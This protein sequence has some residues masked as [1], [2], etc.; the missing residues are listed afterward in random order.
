MGRNVVG[1]KLMANT[2]QFNRGI[3]SA[4]RN[5]TSLDYM[6]AR[7]G[8]AA[9]RALKAGGFD[10]DTQEKWRGRF[11]ALGLASGAALTAG[12][13]M[14]M[15]GAILWQKVFSPALE[16]AASFQK[17]MARMT[18]LAG[19]MGANE[20][21]QFRD[22]ALRIGLRTQFSGTE[23][24]KSMSNLMT[25]GLTKGQAMKTVEPMIEAIEA[26]FGEIAPE[27]AAKIFAIAMNKFNLPENLKD[28]GD[29]AKY[30]SDMLFTLKKSSR[31]EFTE[32]LSFLDS[33]QAGP[34]ILNMSMKET[35]ALGTALMR[36]GTSGRRSG[37]QISSLAGTIAKIH[38]VFE[39]DIGTNRFGA[40][41][42]KANEFYDKEGIAGFSERDFKTRNNQVK[43]GFE[44]LMTI[45]KRTNQLAEKT[46]DPAKARAALHALLSEKTGLTVVSAIRDMKFELEGVNGEAGKTLT[47]LDAMMA[48][49]QS[50][51][52]D[53]IRGT[54][55]KG[56]EAYR[57]TWEGT[58]K[59]IEGVVDTIYTLFGEELLKELNPILQSVKGFL[60]TISELTLKSNF[61]RRSILGSVGALTLFLLV[62]G[63]ALLMMGALGLIFA[64]AA[65]G[66]MIFAEAM[67]V[68]MGGLLG[69][70]ALVTF[71]VGMISAQLFGGIMMLIRGLA[72]SK[73]IKSFIDNIGEMKKAWSALMGFWEGN[74]IPKSQWDD[75]DSGFQKLIISILLVRDGLSALWESFNKELRWDWIGTAFDHLVG[76]MDVLGNSLGITNDFGQTGIST[77]EKLG[78][79]MSW[80]LN[81]AIIAIAAGIYLM[82]AM[83]NL[84]NEL[85]IEMKRF[86]ANK[87]LVVGVKIALG[88]IL[89][90]LG[91]IVISMGLLMLM[92]SAFGMGIGMAV[93]LIVSIMAAIWKFVGTIGNLVGYVVGIFIFIVGQAFNVLWSFV[94]ALI[95]QAY[96]KGKSFADS[97]ADGFRNREAMLNKLIGGVIRTTALGTESD[98][99]PEWE[100]FGTRFTSP[101]TMSP[102]PSAARGIQAMQPG[103]STGAAGGSTTNRTTSSNV[104]VGNIIVKS[105]LEDP[106]A[107]KE[108]TSKILKALAG[109]LTEDRVGENNV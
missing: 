85:Y 87:Q 81:I 23:V 56:A 78:K 75:V 84:W 17:E 62:A 88:G 39:E 52:Q 22:K 91:G 51:D 3:N 45:A 28:T 47:G 40:I 35:F 69:V 93:A 27:Q 73:S 103:V 63:V 104:S 96:G 2:R 42:K 107:I 26:S 36:L 99:L 64:L 25:A 24:A 1:I 20:F 14:S 100:S 102:N 101:A 49:M 16:E 76:S 41:I 11:T 89:A 15:S 48:L 109:Q 43:S 66:I 13:V 61:F 38:R 30:V 92:I 94:G 74:T 53:V 32:I 12:I 10:K 57:K 50:F 54:A 72:E 68:T 106:S 19:D 21:S 97:F 46:G 8:T 77:W 67:A 44:I 58:K 70:I 33:M 31:I 9:V 71:L 29:Q 65:P 6:A 83:V 108:M 80:A 34:K 60:E 86:G 4:V 82:A 98:L 18:A 59:I 37:M 55:Q 5:F 7:S 90:V 105:N 95:D 79:M